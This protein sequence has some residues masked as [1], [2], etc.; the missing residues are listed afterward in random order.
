[1][2]V[3]KYVSHN[4]RYQFFVI[5]TSKKLM[6]ITHSPPFNENTPHLHLMGEP[7]ITE[8][9]NDRPPQQNAGCSA[10]PFF[11]VKKWSAVAM[12][13]WD[14]CADTC[15]ICRNALN[16]PSIE[17]QANPSPNNANGL[18][19]AFGTC[20]HVYHLDCVQ[21]WL[22]TRSVCPLCNKEWDFSKIEKI[23]GYD[24]IK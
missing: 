1:L 10:P 7:N 14:I 23:P 16:E 22:K 2:C 18:S 4:W 6:K 17:Y 15:A 11:D 20:S 12:W 13:S 5:V 24:E 19:I 8:S 21:R 9:S 3:V